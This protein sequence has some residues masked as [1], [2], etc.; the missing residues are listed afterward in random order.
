MTRGEY[1]AAVLLGPCDV[2]VALRRIPGNLL[3]LDRAADVGGIQRKIRH[4]GAGIDA[5]DCGAATISSHL[6]QDRGAN[7]RVA[8]TDSFDS[9]DWIVRAGDE[10]IPVETIVRYRDVV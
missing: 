6:V 7:N 5:V 1:L 3:T 10:A 9:G 8:W 2:N 4:A